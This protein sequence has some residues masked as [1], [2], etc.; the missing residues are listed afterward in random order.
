MEALQGVKLTRTNSPFGLT[1]LY[2]FLYARDL[3]VIGS[4]R[5]TLFFGT[6][7]FA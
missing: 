7:F 6:A 2:L 4:I 3:I 5:L 1:N